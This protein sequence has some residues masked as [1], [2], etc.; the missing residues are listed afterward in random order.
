MENYIITQSITRACG[1]AWDFVTQ[2]NIFENDVTRASLFCFYT[3]VCTIG[4]IPLN[5]T[6]IL[7][8]TGISISL[9]YFQKV[10]KTLTS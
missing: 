5:V 8:C 9:T 7:A 3:D 10:G 6:R 2:I 4:N 1:L